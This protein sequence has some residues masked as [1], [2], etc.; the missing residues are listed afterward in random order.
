[1]D[2]DPPGGVSRATTGVVVIWPER[3]RT[4]AW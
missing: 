2:P 4:V 1:L 3:A